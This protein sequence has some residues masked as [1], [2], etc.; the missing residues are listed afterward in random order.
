[1]D[2]KLLLQA[3]AL[4]IV[5]TYSSAVAQSTVPKFK[6]Y[7][8]VDVYNGPTA[9]LSLSKNDLTFKTRL[10][11]A[12]KHLKPNF[13]GHYIFTAWGC[14]AECLMGAVIDAKNGKV[15]WWDFTICCWGPETDDKFDPIEFRLDSRLIVFSGLRNEK[16]GDD[17]A[18][19]YRFESGR[20][21]HVRTIPKPR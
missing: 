18:H 10:R 5:V 14:G 15:H 21:V 19:F 11:W 3:A 12:A 7:P 9:P 16:E 2:A 13:A 6:D 1:M 17:G 4:S 20:F 8:S